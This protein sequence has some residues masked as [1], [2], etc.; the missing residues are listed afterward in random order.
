VVNG[1]SG[2]SHT[3]DTIELR[4]KEGNTVESSSLTEGNASS[5]DTTNRDGIFR[6]VTSNTTRSVLNGEG[7]SVLGISG[8]L[9]SVVSVVELASNG[10]EGA[11]R[12]RNPEVG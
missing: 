7:S 9:L 4:S 1:D 12:R 6:P 2:E 3:E 5:G 10:E 8:G 11:F